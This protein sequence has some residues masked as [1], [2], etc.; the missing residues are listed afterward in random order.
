G[1]MGRRVVAVVG[2][3]VLAAACTG[4]GTPA[5][6]HGTSTASRAAPAVPALPAHRGGEITIGVEQWPECLNPILDCGGR[7]LYQTVLYHVLPRAMEY[8]PDGS[9]VPS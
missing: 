7:A 5:P 3:A 8:A 1:A 4:G 2:V 6:S 9:V